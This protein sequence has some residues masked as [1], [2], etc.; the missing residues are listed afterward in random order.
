M[1]LADVG[2][3]VGFAAAA[4]ALA[5]A[6]AAAAADATYGPW[7]RVPPGFIYL[8]GG[9]GDIPLT[10][11]PSSRA[12]IVRHEG[13]WG[14]VMYTDMAKSNGQTYYYLPPPRGF[15][16]VDAGGWVSGR[17]T[18]PTCTNPVWAPCPKPIDLKGM[19]GAKG[20]F[21]ATGGAG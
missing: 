9:P 3:N 1:W 12:P 2:V 4:G 5:A 10:D 7:P 17:D 21:T 18:S 14:R 16:S 19:T 15:T 20:D 8:R 13:P 11:A 6:A